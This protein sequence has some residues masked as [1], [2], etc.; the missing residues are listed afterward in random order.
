MASIIEYVAAIWGQQ[1]LS[2]VSAIQNITCRYFMCVSKYTPNAAV[3]GHKGWKTVG[4]RQKLIVLRVN[5]RQ[6]RMKIRC[7][8]ASVSFGFTF[9]FT[10]LHHIHE[11]SSETFRC[12][13]SIVNLPEPTKHMIIPMP[14]SFSGSQMNTFFF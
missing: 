8:I 11:S 12:I 13:Y 9:H 14:I 5:M 6:F 10:D 1:K 7:G 4:H 2:F 3:Q